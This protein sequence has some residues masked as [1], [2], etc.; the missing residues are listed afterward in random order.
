LIIFTTIRYTN[1][2]NFGKNI[3]PT[4]FL[5]NKTDANTFYNLAG[6]IKPG[7]ILYVKGTDEMS[8]ELTD[9]E[10]VIKV[11]YKGPLPSNFL[12]GNTCIVTGT[13]TDP[14]KPSIFLGNKIMTDHSY[15]SDKWMSKSF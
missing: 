15:N 2:I 3:T 13:I 7:S 6:V 4:Y 5:Q 10:H 12:E 1:N 14:A 8:F 11:F 9:Y